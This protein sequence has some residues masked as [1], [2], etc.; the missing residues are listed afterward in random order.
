MHIVRCRTNTNYLT[1]FKYVT[2]SGASTG[3]YTVSFADISGKVLDKIDLTLKMDFGKVENPALAGA[4]I[5]I[6]KQERRRKQY[7][8]GERI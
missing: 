2:I 1:T 8:I 3:V 5:K 6:K 4:K 7:E